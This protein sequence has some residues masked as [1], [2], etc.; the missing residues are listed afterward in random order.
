MDAFVKWVKLLGVCLATVV[1]CN[2]SFAQ[3]L[4]PSQGGTLAFDEA[5][6]PSVPSFTHSK[7]RIYF[8]TNR[9]VDEDAQARVRRAEKKV[10]FK[11]EDF[12]Q[13]KLH[14]ELTYGFIEASVPPAR[15]V[16][17]NNFSISRPQLFNK[18][19]DFS[20]SIGLMKKD[21]SKLLFVP[22]FR[23]TFL[24]GMERLAQLYVDTNHAG[25][26]VLFSWP[27]DTPG[28]LLA[29]SYRAAV[30]N[31]SGS[32]VFLAQALHDVVLPD[33]FD[34]ITHSVGAKVVT[35]AL[36]LRTS[37]GPYFSTSNEKPYPLLNLL[38]VAPD[39][40]KRAFSVRRDKLVELARRGVTKYCSEDWALTLAAFITDRDDR[41]GYCDKIRSPSEI[42]GT[43]QIRVFGAIGGLT[44]H[45]FYE[46]SPEVLSDITQVIN[47]PNAFAST[48]RDRQILVIPPPVQGYLP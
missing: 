14:S 44:T 11:W 38:L 9:L 8:A 30:S 42:D 33:Q 17:D 28:F 46:T 35:E 25:I 26:P 10:V 6:F 40:G 27:S 2:T 32:S 13:N 16:Q 24:D 7:I 5:P 15:A 23:N 12:F 43:T 45:L 47:G 39:I 48:P 41:L 31:A 34:I 19:G 36:T 29:D 37:N 3:G 22:G 21:T 4:R 1:L 20:E 18:A